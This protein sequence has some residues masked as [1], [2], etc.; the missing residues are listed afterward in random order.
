MEPLNKKKNGGIDLPQPDEILSRDKEL[1]KGASDGRYHMFGPVFWVAVAAVVIWN[2]V[3]VIFSLVAY[4]KAG[5]GKLYYL[6]F[7]GRIAFD[8]YFGPHAVHYP[9]APEASNVNRP[10]GAA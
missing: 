1:V 7:F 9:D 4:V 5:K 2:L 6:P 10:P 8:R 3:Y